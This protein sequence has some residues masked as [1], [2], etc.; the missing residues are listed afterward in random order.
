MMEHSDSKHLRSLSAHI[1]PQIALPEI[2]CEAPIDEALANFAIQR[3]RIGAMLYKATKHH[4]NISERAASLLSATYH[5]NTRSILAQRAALQKI[6]KLLED[7]AIPFSTLKGLG[8]A[9]QIYDDPQTRQSKDIDI[10]IPPHASRLA[11]QLLSANGYI[12]KNY[13]LRAN[14]R[15]TLKRQLSDMK[16][17][18]DLTFVD[19]QFSTAIELHQRLFKVEPKNLTADF[20]GAINFQKTPSVLDSFYCFY[21]ILHGAVSL[22][23][24]LKWLVDVSLLVRKMPVSKRQEVMELARTYG[25][26][27]TIIASLRFIDEIFD[28]SLDEEWQMILRE[29]E[30]SRDIEKLINIFRKSLMTTSPDRP[31][32]PLRKPFYFDPTTALFGKQIGLFNIIRTRVVMSIALRI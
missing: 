22:W 26:E 17:F 27:N 11:I 14:K 8:I 25:C 9:D 30:H 19:P 32:A 10:Q 7:H 4:E 24:R 1:R 20:S 16:L 29:Q 6:T 5:K 13:S 21:I 28:G 15:V 23:M 12:Y 31:D 18:K 2:D 3:H